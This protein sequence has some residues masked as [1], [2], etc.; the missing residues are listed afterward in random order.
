MMNK[1]IASL[2]LALWLTCAAAPAAFGQSPL[3]VSVTTGGTTTPVSA[4][5]SLTL[6]STGLGQAV[7]AAVKVS[8]SGS[9][10]VT[11]TAVSV[12]G[13]TEIG[14]SSTLPLPLTLNPSDTTSFSVQYLPAS[15]NAVTAQVSIAYS[16][17]TQASSFLFSLTGTAPRL[18]FT[19]NFPPSVTLTALNGGD[20]IAFPATNLGSSTAVTVNVLNAGTATGSLN[21]ASVKGTG[22]QI[23][24]SPAP[25]AIPAGQEVSVTLQFTPQTAASSQGSLTLSFPNSSTTFALL[26]TGTSPSFSATYTLADGNVHP[27]SNGAAISFP[28][29][30]INGTTSATIVISNQGTGSGT[31]TAISVGGAGFQVTGLPA[32]PATVAA[33]QSLQFRIVFTPTQGGSF[34]GTLAISFT[35]GSISGTL[36]GSTSTSNISLSYIDPSTNSN[37]PLQ[38][39]ST[40]PFPNTTV[41]SVANVALVALNTGAGTGFLNSI[42]LGGANASAFQLLN[43]PALPATIGPNQ[44]VSFGIRFTPLQPQA[45]SATLVVTVN[46]QPVSINLT[47]S[48]SGPQY[49]YLV[50]SSTGTTPL[51]AGGAI[52]I[53]AANVGQT[54]NVTISITNNGNTSGQ[55]PN[56]SVTGQGLSL[57]NLPALPLTL[58][59]GG[60]QQFTLNYAPTQSGTVNGQLTIGSATFAVNATGNAQSNISLAYTDPATNSTL[61]L[62][63]NSTL[64]FPTTTIGSSANITVLAINSGTATGVL[65]SVALGG[66]NASAFQ[67]LNLPAFPVNVAA[68]QQ[69]TFGIRFTPQQPQSYSATLTVTV[70]GQ[71]LTVSLSGQGTGAQF[72]YSVTTTSGTTALAAGGTVAVAATNV[73]QT[74]SVTISI[75]NGGNASGQIPSISVG[76]QGLSLSNLPPLPLTL[77]PNG[78]AQFTLN[79][80]PT[81]TGPVTG[82]LTIGSATF[83]VSATA[84][85]GTASFSATY[86]LADGNVHTLNNGDTITFPSVDIKGTTTAT[87]TVTNT[88]GASGTVTAIGVTGAGFQVTGLPAFPATVAA[89]QSLRFSIVFS[90]PQ[91]GSFTGTFSVTYNNGSLSGSLAASTTPSNIS[92]AYTDPSTNSTLGLQNNATLPFP[93]TSVGSVTNITML[94]INSGTGSASVSSIVLSGSNGSVFQL[95]NLPSFPATVGPAQ[96]LSF[97][98]RFSPQQQQSYSGTIVVTVNGQALAVNLSGQGTSAQYTYFESTGSGTVTLTPGSTISI[99]NTTVGQTTS[100][101]ISFTNNGNASGQIAAISVSGQGLTV[102]SLPPLPLTLAP[103]ATQQFTLNFAPTQA[104]AVTGQL[105]IGSATFPVSATGVSAQ[106]SFSATYALADGNVHTLANGT[107]ITFSPVDINVTTT[108]TI[109]VSNQGGGSGTITGISV[110]GTAFQT[111]GVPSLP[112]TVAANQSLKFGIVFAPTQSGTYSGSF[113]IIYSNGSVSGNLSAST[114]PSN[115]S[116]AYVDPATNNTLPL[117]NN[118]TLPFPN[119]QVGAVANINVLTPNTGTG[120][121]FINSIVIGGPSA[122]AFQLLN[123]PAFPLSVPPSQQATFGIRFTPTQQQTYS[124]TLTVTVNGQP[125]TVNLSAQGIAPQYTYSETTTSGT[126]AFTGG[127]AV[128]VPNTNVGQ[129]TSVTITVTNNGT[130]NGQI[131]VIGVTGQGLSLTNLPPLPLTLATGAS[132]QF[133]LNYAPTQPGA[134]NGQLTI[135]SASF[136]LTGTGVGPQLTYSYANSAGSNSV[137]SGGTVI[138]APIAVGST[139]S[140]SFT[141]QNTGT[142]AATISSIN[143]AT[144]STIFSL[145]Q[146]PGLPLSLAPNATVTFNAN[147]SPNNTGLLTATLAIDTSAFTLSGTGTPPPSLPSYQFQGPSGSVAA[148]QQPSIGLT[149]SSAYPLALQGSLT[150]TFVSDV[151]TNDPSIQFANGGR[152]VNFTIP[153]NATQAIFDGNNSKVLLQS[154]TTAGTIVITPSFATQG[155]FNLTPSSPNTLTLAVP[156]AVPQ[157]TAASI[158]SVT[159]NSFTLV[160]NGYST[161]RVLNSLSVQFT[162]AAGTNLSTSTLSIPVGT[163]ATAWFQSTG[164]QAFGGGFVIAIPFALQGGSSGTNLVS[165]LQSLSITATN[166]AGTSSAVSVTIP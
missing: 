63:N 93:N 12:G 28:S 101:T 54:A 87:V 108:A 90:P 92:L 18:T 41:G 7:S 80:A 73:G 151:F 27:L 61:P 94:V 44:Q 158:N 55:I 118:G 72:T 100:V 106:P 77:T 134:V 104:N 17:A 162:P 5:G 57:T 136:T 74:T 66:T 88:G 127:G 96:Q 42:I 137:V 26:G 156:H 142:S 84:N 117:Q 4:G 91:S 153:A 30:D 89:N 112:A 69:A 86:T 160:L 165:L 64:P 115:I 81:Q 98:V 15:G 46:G 50:T 152:T 35:G 11:I 76:G 58:P 139:E 85:A 124:A 122:S 126:T 114:A 82:Q 105:T 67:L 157:L 36:S 13:T 138:F 119:T 78:T 75:A 21:A 24:S 68:N 132:A 56:I 155:G 47:A 45:Y 121:G 51:A 6:V 8:N 133:T 71:P 164:S 38:N 110:S 120:T 166:D 116:L 130:G 135:G 161:T 23:S 79:F 140:V 43:L 141:V 31:V 143:L 97:G 154:G 144:A 10:P 2:P 113:S 3:Q 131:A 40:L 163:A 65:N 16:L 59:P 48:G 49:S 102:T 103:G 33:G 9:S 123:L 150:L 129:T 159:A 95:L 25:V 145:Q 32:L 60:S 37:L 99:A 111:S 83:A 53:A 19:Y 128:A 125:L 147:F 107:T 70:N 148:A 109:T 14:L 29:V 34:T 22:F 62:P 1:A 149:L 146:L 52:T 39:N 20:T